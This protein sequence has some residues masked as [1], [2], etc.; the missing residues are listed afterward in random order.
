MEANQLSAKDLRIGNLLYRYEKI[1]Y[2][3]IGILQKIQ[4]GSV[5]YRPIPI[6]EEWLLNLGFENIIE[7]IGYKHPKLKLLGRWAIRKSF[8]S[9][10]IISKPFL[11]FDRLTDV[12]YVH[13]LQNIFFALT[14]EE[15]TFK[16]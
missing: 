5:I 14:G 13:Q 6:S 2:V 4:N 1:V 3:N 9:D 8:V 11:R 7:Y 12:Y 10:E 16:N 15:L